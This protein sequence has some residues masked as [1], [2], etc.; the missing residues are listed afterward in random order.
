M[1]HFENR[2]A[3]LLAA[4]TCSIPLAQDRAPAPPEIA[5][6]SPAGI[7][8]RVFGDMDGDALADLYVLNP[9]GEDRLFRN[10]GDGSFEDVTAAAGLAGR[11]GTRSAEW[12]DF[13]R[14]GRLDLLLLDGA[15]RVQVFHGEGRGTF[16]EISSELGIAGPGAA[17]SV[18][19]LDYDAD[20]W[21]D[22]ALVV[23]G[24][25]PVFF[26]GLGGRTFERVELLLPGEILIATEPAVAIASLPAVDEARAGV[27][28]PSTNVDSAS[29]LPRRAA[30][31]SGAAEDSL[32][33]SSGD[34]LSGSSGG[35]EVDTR[36][37]SAAM[38]G[39]IG[40]HPQPPKVPPP[41]CLLDPS[42]MTCV[43]VSTVPQFGALYPL[44]DEF[45]IDPAGNVRIGIPGP[46]SLTFGPGPST[47]RL[48]VRIE[49]T[50]A[51]A[52]L[53]E[54]AAMTGATEGVRGESLSPQ[55]RGVS[56][57]APAEGVRGVATSESG[58]ARGVRGS[59]ASI[60][61]EGVLGEATEPTGNNAGLRGTSASP[62]GR[63]VDGSAPREGVRGLAMATSGTSRG[64]SGT[65]ASTDGEGVRGEVTAT[66]GDNAG[67]RGIS[68]SA[69]GRG[70]DG[71]APSEGVRGV[72][73]ATS[74]SARGVRGTSASILGEG[75]LGEAT[76]TTGFI[77]GVR[78]T[79]ASSQGTGVEGV[80]PALGVRGAATTLQGVGVEGIGPAVGVRGAGSV[81]GVGVE[82]VGPLL[83]VRGTAT[84]ITATSSTGVFGSSDSA[85]GLGVQGKGFCGVQGT[86][87]RGAGTGVLGEA[88]M[89]G[90]DA[91]GVHGRSL[92]TD[93]QSAGV[94]AE[95]NG[96]DLPG[97]RQAAALEVRNGAITVNGDIRPAGTLEI[98]PE[99][100]VSITG[101]AATPTIGFR[102]ERMLQNDLID[103]DCILL[104]TVACDDPANPG[105]AYFA[106]VRDLHPG[107]ATIRIAC[108]GQ[109]GGPCQPPPASAQVRV[110]YLII[111]PLPPLL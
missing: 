53:G 81:D 39:P 28:A 10:Q 13:D 67:L 2:P 85:N 96:V 107:Q 105:T 15:G 63:G 19:W 87:D 109:A 84:A 98:T 26:H 7:P 45:S 14:D 75:M 101:C 21:L 34:G 41:T 8:T 111:N 6:P 40:G 66:N 62:S 108:M 60:V 110:N 72:A 17:Q 97:F 31:I 89:L 78:G 102:M 50:D 104:L 38:T 79:T 47:R 52:V 64:V 106:D 69:S 57:E 103:E 51:I 42:S 44:G 1:K 37:A 4:I 59:S 5:A 95:G 74:G 92:S 46:P 90:G 18:D 86:S 83:G 55:G 48:H 58:V 43:S 3:S 77:A 9:R 94:L 27:L 30:G 35:G 22:L 36:N 12:E 91:T 29:G 54:S 80:G 56:G 76:A 49:E 65:S 73:T 88:V 99:G 100:W 33:G 32:S 61:G 93:V 68:A 11:T 71:N 20:G 24:R 23:P 70:V 25:G 82:G 16:R